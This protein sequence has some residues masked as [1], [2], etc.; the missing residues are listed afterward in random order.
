MGIIQV[1]HAADGPASTRHHE[2]VPSAVKTLYAPRMDSRKRTRRHQQ[3]IDRASRIAADDAA[4]LHL[5]AAGIIGE[6]LAVTNRR[7]EKPALLFDG[8]FA[9][10][11]EETIQAAGAPVDSAF[12]RIPWPAPAEETEILPMEPESVDLI[13]SV[14]DL[15]RM[16]DLQ[17]ALLQ[18]NHA[19]V[20]DGLFM[21]VL[22]AHGFL[23]EL[24]QALIETEA[25]LSSAAATRIEHFHA[26]SEIGNLMHQAGFKLIV[27]DLEER[28]VRYRNVKRLL[29][30][31][32][33]AAAASLLTA[34]NPPLAGTSLAMLEKTYEKLAG[35]PDGRIRASAPMVFA[36]GWKHAASQ[37]QPLKPGS[38]T[39]SL[40]DYLK[41]K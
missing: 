15:Q 40:K 22:P 10:K 1:K 12:H 20:A 3:L 38:A 26:A 9:E 39:H 21:A 41:N 29:G 18:V 19:L 5:D 27:T 13:I 25:A 30:D 31:I 4:F 33:S 14:F 34:E 8:P 23:A 36:T 28:T 16:A 11:I 17:T 7:F 37:Q 2:T 32:R 6:R 35:E 24:R